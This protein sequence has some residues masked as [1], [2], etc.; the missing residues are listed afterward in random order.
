MPADGSRL[1]VESVE[2][3]TL[4]TRVLAQEGLFVGELV[5][6]RADL[7]SVFLRLT[8]GAGLWSTR[9]RSPGA[10]RPEAPA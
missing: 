10:D 4:I 5:P 3:P 2:D 7:E 9:D 6:D 8:G 1:Y